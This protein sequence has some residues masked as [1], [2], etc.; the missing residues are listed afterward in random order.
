VWN[1]NSSKFGQY[2]W[3]WNTYKNIYRWP[4]TL[5]YIFILCTSCKEDIIVYLRNLLRFW[6]GVGLRILYVCMYV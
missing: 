1:P 5:H 3:R 6:K 2:F 4:W